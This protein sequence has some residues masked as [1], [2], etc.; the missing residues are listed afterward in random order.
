MILTL[1]TQDG[2]EHGLQTGKVWPFTTISTK[3]RKAVGKATLSVRGSLR[4][5][6]LVVPTAPSIEG[7]PEAAG[8]ERLSGKII[9]G[10]VTVA[11]ES[12]HYPVEFVGMAKSSV[13]IITGIPLPL[14]YHIATFSSGMRSWFGSRR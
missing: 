9:K 13:M 14:R 6:I 12:A 1:A 10:G 7:L 3:K 5:L 8:S 2:P 11:T 4:T